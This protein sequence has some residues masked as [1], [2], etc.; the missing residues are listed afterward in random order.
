MAKLLI[1][2]S[3]LFCLFLLPNVLATRYVPKWKKQA[4][5]VP[6]SQNEHSHYVC[7]DNGEVQCLHGWTGDL[8]DVPRCR[9]GC[10][11]MQGYCKRPFECRCKL[12][13]YGDRCNK[14]IALPG[15]Q[16]GY[17]NTSFECICHEGWDGLFCS[18][19]ICRL[20]CHATRGYC[21][22][23]GECRCRLGWSGATC[24]D[25]QVL[26]GCQHG[27]CTKPLECRCH[28]GY[29]GLLCQSPICAESC[30]KERGYC[31]KPGE[32]RCRVGWYGKNCDK[33][34]PYPGCVNGS[35]RRPWECNCKTGWGGMLCD[36][37]LTYC[38]NNPS[39]CENGAKCVPLTVEDGNYRCL[40]REGF[41]GRNCEISEMHSMTSK[42]NVTITSTSTTQNPSSTTAVSTTEEVPMIVTPD[43]PEPTIDN[44]AV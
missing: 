21:E 31:R 30:H 16:H 41:T 26:P 11:P 40:C 5:E 24:K 32:C 2:L 37:E 33:C 12:G 23:P 1:R 25:C 35:C 20:D 28:P 27:Y 36:E 17:C 39:L 10:D 29:T 14:C 7:D 9:K 34:Y 38:E 13:Y 19:P 4:C 22:M 6:S 42:P 18:E 44:E 3:A 43:K 15:C 8:C